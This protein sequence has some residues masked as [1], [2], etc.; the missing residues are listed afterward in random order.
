LS[1]M[2]LKPASMAS[3]IQVKFE[4]RMNGSVRLH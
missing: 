2:T 4:R 3:A 1:S